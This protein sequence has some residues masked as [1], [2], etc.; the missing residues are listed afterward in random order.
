MSGIENGQREEGMRRLSHFFD[1]CAKFLDEHLK[2]K[3]GIV[4]IMWDKMKVS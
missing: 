4:V 2:A 1:F 3:K